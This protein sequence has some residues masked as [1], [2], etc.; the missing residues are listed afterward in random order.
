MDGPT[1]D[2]TGVIDICL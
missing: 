2:I 1:L